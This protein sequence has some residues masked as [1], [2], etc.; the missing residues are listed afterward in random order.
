[1][2][3]DPNDRHGYTKPTLAQYEALSGE[4]RIL[5]AAL[6]ENQRLTA[7]N[8]RLSGAEY[9]NRRRL[10]R[11]LAE[12]RA[13]L[14]QAKDQN[15][16]DTCCARPGFDGCPGG[17]EASCRVGTGSSPTRPQQQR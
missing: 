17:R 12:A 15:P 10:E 1:M 7:E 9:V 3:D 11:E 4:R 6:T 2:S 16:W 8:N 14:A 5:A 13:E